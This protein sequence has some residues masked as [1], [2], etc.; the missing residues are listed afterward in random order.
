MAKNC[1]KYEE[2][3]IVKTCKNT[4][5]FSFLLGMFK[6]NIVVLET[7]KKR[8]VLLLTQIQLYFINIKKE[9][10]IILTNMERK[11]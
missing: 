5:F 11:I 10:R 8:N 6:P 4:D 7:I 1:Y 2:K 9:M 3:E